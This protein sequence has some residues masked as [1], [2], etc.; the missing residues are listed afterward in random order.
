MNAN[1]A[2]ELRTAQIQNTYTPTTVI[3]KMLVLSGSV[4]EIRLWV[5]IIETKTTFVKLLPSE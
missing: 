4:H 2:H 1:M 3:N 5:K